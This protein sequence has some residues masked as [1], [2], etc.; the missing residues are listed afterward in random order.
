MVCPDVP[1]VIN[2]SPNSNRSVMDANVT[3]ACDT[4]YI[5]PDGTIQQHI[6]CNITGH[7]T[8]TFNHCQGERA[9]I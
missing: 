4:G 6:I 2:A 5:F 8:P 7:W 9:I 1:I 3:Y